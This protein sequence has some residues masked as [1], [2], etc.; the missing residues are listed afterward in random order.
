MSVTKNVPPPPR[1]RERLRAAGER[2]GRVR[3]GSQSGGGGPEGGGAS[4]AA[5][6]P[7]EAGATRDDPG[8]QPAERAQRS[9]TRP[10]HPALRWTY[11]S[12]HDNAERPLKTVLRLIKD[13]LAG[14]SRC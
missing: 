13:R 5:A 14:I 6:G 2:S 7:T 9:G 8:G 4:G 11:I 3:G 10:T 12:S 1:Q